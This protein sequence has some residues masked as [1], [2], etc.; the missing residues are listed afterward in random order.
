MDNETREI[1]DATHTGP[2]DA[3]LSAFDI[4][5]LS[6]KK[7]QSLYIGLGILFLLIVF[8]LI[9]S[10]SL[11]GSALYSVKTNIL[12]ETSQVLHLGSKSKA[13]YQVTRL[14]TRLDELKR[15]TKEETV[16]EKTITAFQTQVDKHSA[17]LTT[18]VSQ[19]SSGFTME[20]RLTALNSFASVAGAMELLSEN[21][22]KLIGLGD[23]L[24][25]IRRET[26]NT[27]KDTVDMFVQSSTQ[28]NLFAYIKNQ[29]GTVSQMLNEPDISAETIDDAENYIDRVGPAMSGNNF[30]RAIVATAEALRFIEMERYVGDL[31][32]EEI[33]QMKNAS[34]TASTTIEITSTTTATSSLIE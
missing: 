12:E 4:K 27:F 6:P 13:Q 31:I 11:P 28:E 15:I 20:E 29:L 8:L 24:E 16:N 7:R 21:D 3:V 10:Q 19:E 5:D 25:D 32:P 9:A 17:T 18:L 26:V 22:K 33:P 30:A 14:E 2:V 34:S 1:K 23:H